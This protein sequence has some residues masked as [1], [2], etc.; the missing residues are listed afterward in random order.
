MPPL[1]VI[2][3]LNFRTNRIRIRVSQTIDDRIAIVGAANDYINDKVVNTLKGN[4][5]GHYQEFD[6][7]MKLADAQLHE[8]E[9]YNLQPSPPAT[10][11]QMPIPPVE[12][13]PS[14]VRP[15]TE[16]EFDNVPM[17]AHRQ[18]HPPVNGEP[19]KLKVTLK[20]TLSGHT[21][22]V[23]SIDFHPDGQMLVSGSWDGNIKLWSVEHHKEIAT[24]MAQKVIVRAVDFSPDGRLIASASNEGVSQG[25][26][27]KLWSIQTRQPTA[28]LRPKLPPGVGQTAQVWDIAFSPDGRTLASVGTWDGVVRLWS[29]AKQ[30]STRLLRGN[31]GGIATP[32]HCLAISPVGD[33]LAAASTRG[34]IN[35]WSITAQGIIATFDGHVR[36]VASVAFSPDGCLLASGAEDGVKLW[37]L[38]TQQEMA[39]LKGK[40]SVGFS[41]DGQL[42]ATAAMGSTTNAI[43]LWDIATL[44][45]VATLKGHRDSVT[46]LAFSPDGKLLAS[47]SKDSTLKLWEVIRVSPDIP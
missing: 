8:I 6:R 27:I 11:T 18:S 17:A 14:T 45:T 34:E 22:A 21:H 15:T 40:G 26:G 24:L 46:A 32:V 30:Q 47:G 38:T 23:S 5:H 25:G 42:L 4:Y 41:P 19:V 12:I 37:D 1:Y 28:T 13:T 43:K 36:P 10:V 3:R 35:V 29:V 39:T 31:W 2:E 20:E 33:L 44:Q 9:V 7:I 16:V